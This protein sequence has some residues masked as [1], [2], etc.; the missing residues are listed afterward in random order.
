M[1]KENF[2][3]YNIATDVNR[4]SDPAT[5]AERAWAQYEL[6]NMGEIN[7]RPRRGEIGKKLRGMTDSHISIASD[8]KDFESR[9]N[10]AEEELNRAIKRSSN[11]LHASEIRWKKTQKLSEPE[12]LDKQD[13]RYVEIPRMNE[14]EMTLRQNWGTI[15]QTAVA[16]R[17]FLLESVPRFFGNIISDTVDGSSRITSLFRRMVDGTL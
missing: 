7:V 12:V 9:M 1:I 13:S 8:P 2:K 14:V 16:V 10:L 15:C 17:T 6:A 5:V 4:E 3:V 11:S